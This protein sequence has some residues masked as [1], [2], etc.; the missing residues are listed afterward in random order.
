MSG[1]ER[2]AIYKIHPAIGIANIGNSPSDF[3]VASE[4][5]MTCVDRR[6][7]TGTPAMQTISI[8][9]ASSVEP[10]S[11]VFSVMTRPANALAKSQRIA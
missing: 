5:V 4:A 1:G 6:R 10:Q 3:I 11:S 9:P 8:W 2:V 7:R